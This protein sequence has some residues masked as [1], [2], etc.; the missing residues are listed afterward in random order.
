MNDKLISIPNFFLIGLMAYLFV[1][2]VD[3]LLA[4]LGPQALKF[5]I[6]Q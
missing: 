5:T 4:K 2:L 1:Y 3:R 6:A